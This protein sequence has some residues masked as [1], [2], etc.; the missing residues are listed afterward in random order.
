MKNHLSALL[1][2]LLFCLAV[3]ALSQV[4]AHAPDGG[5]F[6]RLQSVTI[7]PK[8]G[9]S[10]SATVV[11]EWTRL[12]EDGTTTMV[13]NHRTGALPSGKGTFTREDLGT[14]WIENLE[15]AGSREITT[16]NAGVM[17]NQQPEPTVKEFWYSLRLEVN[18]VTH[19]FEPRGGVQNFT[20]KDINLAEPDPKLFLPPTGYRVIRTDVP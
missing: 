5:S 18:L 3:N 6:E 15:T 4:S 13:K 8:A 11:T 9:A 19:R 2:G 17:G 16:I 14:K 7:L 1:A 12:L 20:L 10:F